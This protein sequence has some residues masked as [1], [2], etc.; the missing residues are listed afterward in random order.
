MRLAV[1][2]F[3]LEDAGAVRRLV[4]GKEALRP[5]ERDAALRLTHAGG[6]A[7]G[8]LLDAVRDL[9][10]VGAHLAVTAHPLL[11]RRGELLPSRLASETDLLEPGEAR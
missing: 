10:R 5:A 6:A 11:E 7:A 9:R 4:R 8:R 2:V 1:A 3:M